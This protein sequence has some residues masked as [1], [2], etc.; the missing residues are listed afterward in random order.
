MY[1]ELLFP[2][3]ITYS[4]GI[5]SFDEKVA[6]AAAARKAR[7]EQE[8]REQ[9]A[10]EKAE[11]ERKAREKAERERKAYEE[12]ERNRRNNNRYQNS[13]NQSDHQSGRQSSACGN[14][15]YFA[16][17]TNKKELKRRYR[18]LC[19]KLHPDCPGG[20]AESFRLMQAEYDRLNS[21]LAS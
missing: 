6:R 19:K 9:A 20:N 17:V 14:L 11:R 10:R 4:S 18:Q 7:E 13:N 2:S 12:A 21:R 3:N 1:T 15:Y 8:R 5:E 16:G